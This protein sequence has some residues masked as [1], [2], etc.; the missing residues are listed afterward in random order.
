MFFQKKGI[1]FFTE[2]GKKSKGSEMLESK[3]KFGIIENM[4]MEHIVVVQNEID[5]TGG[6]PRQAGN[7]DGEYFKC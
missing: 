4:A 1:L 2:M 7:L 5:S 6:G 3:T